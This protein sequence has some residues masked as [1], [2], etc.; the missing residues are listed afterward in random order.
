LGRIYLI[1]HGQTAW[2]KSRIFRGRAD[3][4]L[5]AHGRREAAA[6]AQALSDAALACVYASPLSRTRETAENIAARHGVEV[7]I[8]AAFTD[9]DYGKW[10]THADKEVRR[11]FGELYEQWETSPQLVRFPDGESLADVRG[12]SVPRLRELAGAHRHETIGV[13]THRVVLKVLLCAI[14]GYDN[15]RFWDVRLDPASIS[16]AE[17]DG[18][19]GF[20]LIAENDT[21]HLQ[22]LAEKDVV[23]F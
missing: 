11:T 14:K 1:R 23:D 16:L 7:R 20:K 21:H 3:V 19:G 10:T 15:A 2:N 17:S 8:D 6:A 9:I 5:N 4:T 22:S 12:R 18:V 13:V